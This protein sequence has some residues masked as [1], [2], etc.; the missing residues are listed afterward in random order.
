[1]PETKHDSCFPSGQFLIDGYNTGP[2][3]TSE[4]KRG[5]CDDIGEQIP[6]KLLNNQTEAV[7]GLYTE[8]N[9]RN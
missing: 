2:E 1:M 4:Q 8:V 6:S 3:G 7:E 9:L 5:W